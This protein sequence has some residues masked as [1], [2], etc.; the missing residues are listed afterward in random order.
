VDFRVQ[1]RAVGSRITV[2]TPHGGGIE[3]GTADIALA[4]ADTD[5]SF[6]LSKEQ[7]AGIKIVCI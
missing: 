2:I 3:P 1:S 5:F 6:T 4:I 7:N